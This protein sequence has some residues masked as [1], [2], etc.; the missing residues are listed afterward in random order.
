MCGA[1]PAK[2]RPDIGH[3]RA[4]R[5]AD[6]SSSHPSVTPS[7]L[8]PLQYAISQRTLCTMFFYITTQLICFSTNIPSDSSLYCLKSACSGVRVTADRSCIAT[9]KPM[10]AAGKV[11]VTPLV[12]DTYLHRE[13]NPA[14]NSQHV[15]LEPWLILYNPFE[16]F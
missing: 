6:C 11:S 16:K 7:L 5:P 8:H 2:R 9:N 1:T 12:C 4:A 3:N 13:P 15:V 10:S 14:L